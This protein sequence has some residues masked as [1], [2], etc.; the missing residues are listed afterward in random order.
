MFE[1]VIRVKQSEPWQ[2][3]YSLILFWN[4]E[5][6]TAKPLLKRGKRLLWKNLSNFFLPTY[7]TSKYGRPTFRAYHTLIDLRIVPF[8]YGMFIAYHPRESAYK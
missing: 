4:T 7:R 8:K 6:Y 2:N 1:G 3:S 5:Y